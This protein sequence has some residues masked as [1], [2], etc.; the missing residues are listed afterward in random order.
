M[1]FSILLLMA[2][3]PSELTYAAGYIPNIQFAP[4]Y[5]AQARG[6]YRSEGIVLTLDYTIGPDVFKLVALGRAHMGSADPDAFLNA[7]ARGLPLTHV[8]TLYQSYPIALISKQPILDGRQLKGKRIGISGAYGSSYLGLK[9]ILAEMGL[10]LA[11]IRLAVIGY[12]QVTALRQDR[13]DA[14]V[15]YANNEPIL[16]QQQGQQVYVRTLGANRSLPGVG[17]MTSREFQ[18]KNPQLVAGFLRASFKGMHDIIQDPQACFELVMEHYLPELRGEDAKPVQ[19]GILSATLPYWQSDYVRARGFGQ[20]DPRSWQNLADFM[21]RD[22]PGQTF[23]QW[24]QWV[25]ASF[26]WRPPSP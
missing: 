4:F 9:A 21:N 1:I 11:D 2:A 10:S 15:G 18:Q 8:A 26:F 23:D 17:L 16:L 14:V 25:D 24:K 3:E 5:V 7:S 12:T 22:Q 13:V 6:Y 19:F 20:A